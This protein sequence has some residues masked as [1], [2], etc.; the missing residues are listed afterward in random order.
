MASN[1]VKEYIDFSKKNITKYLKIILE[2]DYSKE[3]IEP[4]LDTYINVRY[5]NNYDI[6]YKAFESNIN[7][8][9]KQKAIK[10]NEEKEEEYI[11]KVK[12]IFYLFKYILYF[13]NVLEYESLKKIISEIDEYRNEVLGLTSENFIEELNDLVK[14]NEKRKE[15][16]IEELSSD[17]FN[18]EIK[19]TNNKN[20]FKV[21]LNN[22]IKFNK[23]YSDYS[24]NKVY[25][26]GLV[27]EQKHFILYYLITREILKN[28]IKGDFTKE[29]I[30]SF[31]N[32][33][34]TKQQKINRLIAIIDD[35][36]I[37]NNIV[38]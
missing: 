17:H 14:E 28:I 7:Y 13:D 26:E 34:F 15:T 24:I 9:M 8:Y 21:K 22:N 5:Y 36:S 33:I 29:Y 2:Q 32:N 11:S 16:F 10:I 4:L 19:N 31:P 1:I 27:D 18:L 20:V 35:E 30:I 37:K 38:I 25:N 3:I 23:I 12:K 6:K